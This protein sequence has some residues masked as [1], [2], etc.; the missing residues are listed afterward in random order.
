MSDPVTLAV[1]C[2][3]PSALCLLAAAAVI[4]RHSYWFVRLT[5]LASVLVSIVPGLVFIE[6][7]LT[8]ALEPL[9]AILGGLLVAIGVALA[10]RLRGRWQPVREIQ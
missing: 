1:L 3:A 5:G 9:V 7:G 4:P 8:G 10:S 6:A 2:L